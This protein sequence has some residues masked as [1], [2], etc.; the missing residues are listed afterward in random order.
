MAQAKYQSFEELV[1][2]KKARELK[3]EIFQLVKS[4]PA[5]EKYRL[6]DQLIRSSHSHKLTNSR[7]TWQANK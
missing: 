3:V 2:W 7:R 6:S 5:D 1:V 4:F